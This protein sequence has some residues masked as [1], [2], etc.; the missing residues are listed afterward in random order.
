MNNINGL[1]N[2]S[3]MMENELYIYF[4][5][6][7]MQRILFYL[8]KTPDELQDILNCFYEYCQTWRQKV[9][10]EKTKIILF[11]R[12]RNVQNNLHFTYNDTTEAY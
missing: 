2:I 5:H 7:F 10:V 3:E 6:C 12:Y 8:Q 4:L 9:N 1:Q 11:C